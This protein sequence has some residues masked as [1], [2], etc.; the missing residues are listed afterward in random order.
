MNIE[1]NPRAILREQSSN[2]D[3]RVASYTST[4]GEIPG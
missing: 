4:N 3:G 1:T 2:I